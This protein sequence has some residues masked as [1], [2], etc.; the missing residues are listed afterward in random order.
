M[1]GLD[2]ATQTA[3]VTN[4]TD[5]LIGTTTIPTGNFGF[6]QG[7]SYVNFLTGNLTMVALINKYDNI[8]TAGWGVPAIYGSGYFAAQNAAKASVAAYTVGGSDGDFEISAYVNVT[9]ATLFTFTVTCIYTDENNKSRTLT[10]GFTQ[11]SGATLLTTMTNAT[12]AG[13]YE[14]PAYHIRAKAGT[15]ITLASAPGGT[16]TTVTYDIGGKIKQTG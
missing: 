1:V 11:L 3:G 5:I 2:V 16:Y 9:T 13:P 10:L 7:D 15:A 6:Y 14:S 8:A 4:N 12:G